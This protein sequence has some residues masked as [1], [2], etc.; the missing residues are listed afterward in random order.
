LFLIRRPSLDAINTFL[1]SQQNA[2]FSYFEVGSTRKQAPT[3]YVVDHN[4]VR[5]GS[6]IA[7]FQCAREALVRWEMFHLGWVKLF[8]QSAPVQPHSTVAVL[9]RHFGFWS[10]NA[11]R[12]V[13]VIDEERRY[14]FAYGTLQDH[15]E[16]GEERFSIEWSEDDDSVWYDI[17]AFSRPHQWQAKFALPLSRILQKKF[18]RDSKAAMV[19]A[20]V[21]SCREESA[22]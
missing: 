11:C 19:R 14:G 18:A 6:G 13:Y 1:A 8:P 21:Q 17:L 9:V 20:L 16:R 4:R 3:G 7:A 5:L 2:E 22:Q 12:V 10:L 15:A